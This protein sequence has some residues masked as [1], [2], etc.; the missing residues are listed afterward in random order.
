MGTG[1]VCMH[2]AQR[3]E[4]KCWEPGISMWDK[5]RKTSKDRRWDI[6]T[7]PH[8]LFWPKPKKNFK[9]LKPRKHDCKKLG[10][11][12]ISLSFLWTI[13]LK[14]IMLTCYQVYTS[15][16]TSVLFHVQKQAFSKAQICLQHTLYTDP[17]AHLTITW[18]SHSL[19]PTT[20]L[21]NFTLSEK[22]F[23]FF[24]VTLVKWQ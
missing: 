19:M 7:W 12:D 22:S 15:S 5:R 17:S 3:Q 24:K 6:S 2:G 18:S 9:S 13:L 23:N 4:S 1:G 10:F 14:A 20:Q 21:F 11:Y 8:A 16:T